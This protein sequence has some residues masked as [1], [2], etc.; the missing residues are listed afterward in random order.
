MTRG[1]PSS[2]Q[3]A[4]PNGTARPQAGHS[5]EGAAFIDRRSWKIPEVGV[6]LPARLLAERSTV[7]GSG[8]SPRRRLK[9]MHAYMGDVAR[10]SRAP[11][12]AGGDCR[13]GDGAV[14]DVRHAGQAALPG[15]QGGG[16][17]GAEAEDRPG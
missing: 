10:L 14:P 2:G 3:I 11:L 1:V 15:G 9:R 7:R 6:F 4:V 8:R 12:R 5:M 13:L 17:E 16:R